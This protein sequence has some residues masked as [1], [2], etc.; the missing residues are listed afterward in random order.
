MSKDSEPFNKG[1]QRP[2]ILLNVG[3]GEQGPQPLLRL[4]KRPETSSAK[5]I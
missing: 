2:F 5:D 4:D 3:E 1:K